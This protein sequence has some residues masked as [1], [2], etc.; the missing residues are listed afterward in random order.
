MLLS[1]NFIHL[2]THVNIRNLPCNP[3]IAPGIARSD[4][5]LDWRISWSENGLNR[6]IVSVTHRPTSQDDKSVI[7]RYAY[8]LLREMAKMMRLM[9]IA[10]AALVWTMEPATA[11]YFKGGHLHEFCN[12]HPLRPLAACIGYIVGVVDASNTNVTGF[13]FQGDFPGK[14]QACWRL[15]GSGVQIDQLVNIVADWLDDHPRQHYKN[16]THLIGQALSVAFPCKP[17]G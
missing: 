5:A 17:A 2:S 9:A 1:H 3:Q 13:Y 8:I 15:G 11:D 10:L 14:F 6:A 12:D 16:A 4:M 7:A